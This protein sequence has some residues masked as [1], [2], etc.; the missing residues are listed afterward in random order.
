MRRA[1]RRMDRTAGSALVPVLVVLMSL[2]V[3]ASAF[4]LT[5]YSNQKTAKG[6]LDDQRAF[7]LAEA[8][9]HEA[10][11]AVR[12]GRSGAV[13]TAAEPALLGGGVVWTQVEDVDLERKR[14]VSTAMAGSGRKALEAVIHMR[15]DQPPL[16]VATLN[17]KE[18]LTLNSG[19]TIDSFDSE[20]GSYASQMVNT[21]QGR[22]Y[23]G[24]NGDVRSNEDIIA[25]AYAVAFG[26]AVPGPGHSV[27]LSTGAYIDG[28]IVPAL[29][30]FD[31]APISFPTFAP[32]GNYTVPTAG[33]AT[34]APGNYDFDAFS[35]SKDATLT[36]TGPASV[37]VDS[38]TGGKAGKLMIDATNGPVTFF[39]RGT[40][41]HLSGFAADAVAGSEM[42]LAFLVDAPQDVVFPASA[43]IRGAYYVP[44]ANITFSSSSECWGAFAANR[45][46]MSNDMKFHFDET[47]GRHWSGQNGGDAD[48]LTVLSWS[49][50][51]ILPASL[52]RDRRD[53]LLVLGLEADDL[54]APGAAWQP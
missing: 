31:F 37:V 24:A 15:P 19:V 40:Y 35:I 46:D 12:D 50:T 51:G 7:F 53:P 11:E 6:E 49:P 41:T 29:E 23:A 2:F 8:G 45:I 10:F 36:V 54:L 39:V 52:V 42:A 1:N 3:M 18:T 5:V 25:N 32:Q 30:P 17:S 26:D 34:L 13:G 22:P 28:S 21:G 14:I 43:K 44:N 38:F 20:V 48:R 9:L 47:L 27:S 16:F 33:S 4:F